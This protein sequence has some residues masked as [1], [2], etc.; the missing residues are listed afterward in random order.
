[1]SS[2]ARELEPDPLPSDLPN[3]A[4][5]MSDIERGYAKDSTPYDDINTNSP[6]LAGR[7]SGGEGSRDR[8]RYGKEKKVKGAGLTE[9]DEG[10]LNPLVVGRKADF[11]DMDAIPKNN[12]W[13]VMPS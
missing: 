6:Q 4:P 11:V 9:G 2:A 5:I 10:Q 13:L 7:E 1:M 8:S 3:K 12:F